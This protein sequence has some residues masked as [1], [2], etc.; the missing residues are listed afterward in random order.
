MAASEP[1]RRRD[2]GD[3]GDPD[4][5]GRNETPTERADRNWNELLQEL[6]VTQTGLQILTGFLL[7]VPFQSR[8]PELPPW[9][10]VVFL[11]ALGLAVAATVLVVTPVALHRILF[12]RRAKTELVT[13]SSRLTKV[14]LATLSLTI[15]AVVVLVFGF[16]L[17][18]AAAVVAGVLALLFFAVQ[19]LVLPAVV[20]SQLA[21]R[22]PHG[23]T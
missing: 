14:G 8:F 16:V 6:R 10:R 15:V 21:A 3:P 17:G 1:S 18:A 7:T 4:G 11:I 9:L 13:I 5:L 20:R 19:W 22:P 12:R 23:E 2:A